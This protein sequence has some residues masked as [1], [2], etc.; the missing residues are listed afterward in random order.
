MRAPL[1]LCGPLVLARRAMVTGFL[2]HREER[3]CLVVVI[4]GGY[5]RLFHGG[6]RM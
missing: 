2:P 3:L 6:P 5:I 4:L 1:Q